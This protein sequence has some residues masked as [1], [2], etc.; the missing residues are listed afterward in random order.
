MLPNVQIQVDM[1]RQVRGM[2]ALVSVWVMHQVLLAK[3]VRD[4]TG[5]TERGPAVFQVVAPLTTTIVTSK[6]A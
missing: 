6:V 3:V 2:L 5:T 4:E 1:T